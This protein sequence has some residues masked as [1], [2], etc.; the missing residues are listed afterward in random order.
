ML[1]IKKRGFRPLS[2]QTLD[3][4]LPQTKNIGVNPISSSSRR[5]G[6]EKSS[7]SYVFSS[8]LK[9]A[10][11]STT[12]PLMMTS[13]LVKLI[14]P[15]QMPENSILT[16]QAAWDLANSVAFIVLPLVSGVLH[17]LHYHYKMSND[18]S[19]C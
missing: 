18:R 10:V 2:F 13:S 3:T 8:I 15:A 5:V 11:T 17:S 7:L 12:F 1:L 16:S 14:D 19:Q 9:E 6:Y 4:G